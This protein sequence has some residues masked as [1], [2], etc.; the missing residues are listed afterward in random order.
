VINDPNVTYGLET[1]T[2][3]H[4]ILRKERNSIIWTSGSAS[5][6]RLPMVVNIRLFARVLSAQKLGCRGLRELNDVL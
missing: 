6:T 5:F 4:E 3:R 1:I 2:V